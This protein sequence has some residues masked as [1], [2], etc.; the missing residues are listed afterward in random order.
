MAMALAVPIPDCPPG[1][2]GRVLF[3]C[4]LPLAYF[5][6]LRPFLNSEARAGLQ[7]ELHDDDNAASVSRDAAFGLVFDKSGVRISDIVFPT[8]TES[9]TPSWIAPELLAKTRRVWS[10]HYGRIV[11]VKEAVQMLERVKR[12]AGFVV[13]S[14]EV[15]A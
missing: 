11:S 6:L 8:K 5:V 9:E 14:M 15:S 10:L 2:Q 3:P 7:V 12:L 4:G 13:Q 1:L